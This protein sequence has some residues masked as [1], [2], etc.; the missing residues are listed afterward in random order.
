MAYLETVYLERELMFKNNAEPTTVKYQLGNC[1]LGV[2][3]DH[4]RIDIMEGNNAYYHYITSV[5]VGQYESILCVESQNGNTFLMFED[6]ADRDEWYSTIKQLQLGKVPSFPTK[7]ESLPARLNDD[8]TTRPIDRS[9]ASVS[10]PSTLQQIFKEQLEKDIKLKKPERKKGSGSYIN[11]DYNRALQNS[12]ESYNMF[13]ALHGQQNAA[14]EDDVYEDVPEEDYPPDGLIEEDVYEDME[15]DSNAIE[16]GIYDDLEKGDDFYEDNAVPG[17]PGASGWSSEAGPPPPPL[18]PRPMPPQMVAE[19]DDFYEMPESDV[20]P[21]IPARPPAASNTNHLDQKKTGKQSGK[22]FSRQSK[23]QPKQ[24]QNETPTKIPSIPTD[25]D[26]NV[27]KAQ[28]TVGQSLADELSM[29]LRDRAATLPN[30]PHSPN[31]IPQ[32]SSKKPVNLPNDFEKMQLRSPTDRHGNNPRPSSSEISDELARKLAKRSSTISSDSAGSGLNGQTSR[33][34][35]CNANDNRRGS[36]SSVEQHVEPTSPPWK[37]HRDQTSQPPKTLPKK[38]A[39]VPPPTLSRPDK[40]QPKLPVNDQVKT[41][42]SPPPTPAKK[43]VKPPTSDEIYEDNV[44]VSPVVQPKP[45]RKP[46]LPSP[47]GGGGEL[48]VRIPLHA[49]QGQMAGSVIFKDESDNVVIERSNLPD[50]LHVGDQ[51][52]KIGDIDVRNSSAMFVTECWKRV[53][54]SQVRV[55]IL[56]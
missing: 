54:E 44:V 8:T 35:T 26:G 39:I 24:K 27:S 2:Y 53:S 1:Q 30:I 15:G 55:R 46:S 51:V 22:M 6:R 38:K 20:P 34:Q 18:P 36:V 41:L 40:P 16:E 43:P 32:S 33:E 48:D 13:N 37:Q 5:T 31:Q 9:Q 4:V 10:S 11:M 29:K 21:P 23:K 56:R 45:K 19:E 14:V 49:I 3:S 17:P 47:V 25:G 50:Y 42:K 12:K 7:R 52:L 28:S